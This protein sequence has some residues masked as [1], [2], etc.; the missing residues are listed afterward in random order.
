MVVLSEDPRPPASQQREHPGRQVSRRVDRV[1]AVVA[2]AQPDAEDREAD[3]HGDELLFQPH[4]AGVRDG[5][6]ADQQQ[7]RAQELVEG[8]A[9]HGEVRAGI[10]REDPGCL[11]DGS[12][13]G[14]VVLIPDQRVPVDQEDEARGG[15]RPRVL[16]GHVVGNLGGK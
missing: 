2:E 11:R 16:G 14:P 12:V 1:A 15:Q 5:A 8:A 7:Q 9:G 10:G 3:A 13:H 6:D 4:V